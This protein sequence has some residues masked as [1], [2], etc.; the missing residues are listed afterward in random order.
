MLSGEPC[1]PNPRSGREQSYT[2]QSHGEARHEGGAKPH[3]AL[4]GPSGT[5]GCSGKRT[6]AL[7]N[8]RA[9]ELLALSPPLLRSLY[10][11]SSMV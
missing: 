10:S 4:V 9:F 7:W 11:S 3:S 2:W 6:I 5:Q 8:R 1:R